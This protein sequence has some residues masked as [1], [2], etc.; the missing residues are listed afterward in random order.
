MYYINFLSSVLIDRNKYLIAFHYK[1]ITNPY[2]SLV[3]ED[4]EGL[5]C[6]ELL[7]IDFILIT[8][9]GFQNILA[10]YVLIEVWIIMPSNQN[11]QE[12]VKVQYVECRPFYEP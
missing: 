8:I 2:L 3:I 1:S 7:W 11:C 9:Y 12:N 10:S 4:L 6:L 5:S